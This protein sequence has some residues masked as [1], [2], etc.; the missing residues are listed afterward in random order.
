LA[1][2]LS[3]LR[4]T[5]TGL[6][7]GLRTITDESILDKLAPLDWMNP[8]T[9]TAKT[10]IPEIVNAGQIVSLVGQGGTGKSLLMFDIGMAMATGQSVLGHTPA[11]PMSVLYIDMENPIG[12]VYTR[13][14]NLGYQDNSLERLTYYH[15]PDLPALD[16]KAGGRFIEAMAERH[17]PDLVIFDTISKL[18]AG[19]ESKSDTWQDLYKYSLVP[20]RQNN[21]AA[22][23]LDHQGHDSSK[24]ARGSSAKR[25]NVDLQWIQG[26]NGDLITLKRDKCRTL[27][28]TETLKIR[29]GGT[30]LRHTIEIDPV[31]ECITFLDSIGFTGG[32]PTAE[33][34]LAAHNRHWPKSVVTE[35]VRQRKATQTGTA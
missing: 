10:I 16:T 5:S 11:E 21:C 20:L 31:Q 34:E 22:L 30:P 29:R 24:G 33:R 7:R 6:Q 27:H 32:R 26:C 18:V 23:I 14:A 17:S 19:E 3:Y 15:M 12:E 35:A 28:D 9:N 2:D 1:F 4:A 13:R 8:P 25:D